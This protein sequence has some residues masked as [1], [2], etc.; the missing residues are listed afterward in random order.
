VISDP[1]KY[2]TMMDETLLSSSQL[3]SISSYAEKHDIFSLF[4]YTLQRLLVEKP[5]DPL[6]FM[7]DLLLKPEGLL[8]CSDNYYLL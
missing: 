8:S 6:Q 1:K 4:Q 7:M 3:E 2:Q 5:V